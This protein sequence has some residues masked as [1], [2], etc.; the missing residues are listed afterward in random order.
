[1]FTAKIVFKKEKV[2]EL[3]YYTG[4]ILFIEHFYL[5]KIMLNNTS[6]NL[7]EPLYSL[8]MLCMLFFNL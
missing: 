1:V 2:Y 3:L 5:E 4:T 6:N 7:K 8:A